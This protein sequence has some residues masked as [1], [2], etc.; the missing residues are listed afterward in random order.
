MRVDGLQEVVKSLDRKFVSAFTA[1]NNSLDRSQASQS[2]QPA[3]P[4]AFPFDLPLT[5]FAAMDDLNAAVL[6]DEETMKLLV[7]CY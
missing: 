6:R 3:Q 2:T 4:E 1:L 7:S 5:T